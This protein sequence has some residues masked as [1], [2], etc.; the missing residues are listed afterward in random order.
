MIVA[1]K[2]KKLVPSFA[3]TRFVT[4][5]LKVP[6]DLKVVHQNVVVVGGGVVVVVGGV[7]VDRAPVVPL[8]PGDEVSVMLV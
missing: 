7:R 5:D 6:F 8:R 1:T 2:K 4:F 3:T